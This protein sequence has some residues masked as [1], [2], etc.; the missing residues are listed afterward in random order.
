M[1]LKFVIGKI[2]LEFV[3]KFTVSLK[4]LKIN[5]KRGKRVMLSNLKELWLECLESR[6]LTT[7]MA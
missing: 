1:V 2:V 4:I 7:L 3:T 6:F 5:G